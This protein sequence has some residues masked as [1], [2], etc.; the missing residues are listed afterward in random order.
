[1]KKLIAILLCAVMLL[2]LA[3]C[4]QETV[5][6]NDQ[7]YMGGEANA[8]NNNTVPPNPNTPDRAPTAEELAAIEQYRKII[9][10]LQAYDPENPE[11]TPLCF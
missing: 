2:S 11:I 9:L 4:G 6:P 8:D 10:M 7:G 1:M 5:V 3:A